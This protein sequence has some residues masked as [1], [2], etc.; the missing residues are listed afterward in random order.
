MGTDNQQIMR[1]FLVFLVLSAVLGSNAAPVGPKPD[2]QHCISLC[3]ADSSCAF[4]CAI[5]IAGLKFQDDVDEYCHSAPVGVSIEFAHCLRGVVLLKPHPGPG[6]CCACSRGSDMGSD[7]W[8]FSGDGAECASCCVKM[9][10]REY[11]MG[12]DESA[13]VCST[14]QHESAVCS[15]QT[16]VS[17]TSNSSIFGCAWAGLIGVPVGSACDDGHKWAYDMGKAVHN[18]VGR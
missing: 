9:T 6:L 7:L 3:A 16:P 8:N 18:V 2:R 14:H 17:S 5:P 4:G 15:T 11:K 12:K 10:G 13:T 1:S